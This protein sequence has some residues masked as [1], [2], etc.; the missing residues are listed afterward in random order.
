VTGDLLEEYRE[1]VLPARGRLRAQLWYLKQALSLVDSV[2][3]GLVLGV[4]FGAWN[5]IFTFLAPLAE[6]T[7]PALLSFYGPMFVMWGAAGFAARRRTGRFVDAIKAGMTVGAVTIAVFC[8]A[9]LL[10]VNLFLEAIS[11]RSDWRNLLANF[12]NSDFDSLR[13]YVNCHFATQFGLKLVAG[14]LIGALSGTIGGVV[15]QFGRT[16]GPIP[17]SQTCHDGD[18]RR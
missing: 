3:F 5:L 11:Q 13:A 1:V 9:N 2:T 6:D 4:A 10:R 15:A 12:H 17:S 8:I 16:R 14:I 18:W 7:V